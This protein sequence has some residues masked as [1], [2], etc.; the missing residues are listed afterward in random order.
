METIYKT[1]Q[2]G[3]PWWKKLKDAFYFEEVWRHFR[4]NYKALSIGHPYPKL[5]LFYG[6]RVLDIR[7]MA[8][9]AATFIIGSRFHSM[10]DF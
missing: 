5:P 4:Y 7:S 10:H 9:T 2:L 1:V 8:D 6:P 3:R